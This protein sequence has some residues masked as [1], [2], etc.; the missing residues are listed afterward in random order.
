MFVKRGK[1]ETLL[2]TLEVA[3]KFEQEM[4]GC[5][6]N[7]IKKDYSRQKQGGT[8]NKPSTEEKGKD[9]M[10]LENLH[11]FIKKLT[12]E[13]IDVKINISESSSNQRPYQ[14]FFKRRIENK[15]FE[16]PLPHANLNIELD[17]VGMDTFCTYC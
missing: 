11:R 16:L 13:I 1:K 2:D 5:K 17:D 4:I 12:N 14:N 15:P 3:K 8:I 7:P 10:D 6:E 9:A